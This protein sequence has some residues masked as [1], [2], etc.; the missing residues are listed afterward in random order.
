[1]K[2]FRQYVRTGPKSKPAV[3]AYV[4]AGWFE[5]RAI[6]KM[7]GAHR[8]N[9]RPAHNWAG[10]RAV[11]ASFVL[12]RKGVPNPDIGPDRRPPKW[13]TWLFDKQFTNF[14]GIGIGVA[15]VPALFD[16]LLVSLAVLT[17][18]VGVAVYVRI[19]TT[20]RGV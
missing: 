20:P 7:M 8:H 5:R 11:G 18:F 2:V 12:R 4:K 1:M 16:M 6:R 14:D 19:K 15:S 3:F 9:L 17:A 10:P 13:L